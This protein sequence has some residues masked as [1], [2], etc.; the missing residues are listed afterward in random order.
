M[1][2][3]L[4]AEHKITDPAKFEEYRVK[5]GPMIAKH[6]GR[7]LTKGGTHK[8]PEGGHWK[9]ERVVIIEFP[10][11]ESLNAC[12]NSPEYQPLIALRKQCTSDLDML[13]TLE[14][15]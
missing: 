9:P 14:G 7:Y 5:V 3:F 13:I 1:T 10:D 6:G 11:M 4:I 12:Y 8:M 15:A 2:A